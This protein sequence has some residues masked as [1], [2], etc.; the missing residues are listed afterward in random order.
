MTV[1]SSALKPPTSRTPSG[2]I[3]KPGTTSTNP[4]FVTTG[5]PA[6]PRS[7]LDEL[8][9]LGVPHLFYTVYIDGKEKRPEKNTFFNVCRMLI[10]MDLFSFVGAGL[11]EGF[12]PRNLVSF[13]CARCWHDNLPRWLWSLL[14]D[15]NSY[16]RSRLSSCTGV[17]RFGVVIWSCFLV[18]VWCSIG[19]VWCCVLDNFGHDLESLWWPVDRHL[20]DFR[21]HCDQW[22]ASCWG[23]F[24]WNEDI[25]FI[26]VGCVPRLHIVVLRFLSANDDSIGTFNYEGLTGK[27]RI[28]GHQ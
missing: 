6:K 20:D 13:R 28:W 14:G 11:A 1:I 23:V 7:K 4:A 12:F 3:E 26:T 15:Q 17:D 21:W 10:H 9:T 25:D 8:W 19:L 24:I 16:R 2:C 5:D 18:V 27:G 22:V